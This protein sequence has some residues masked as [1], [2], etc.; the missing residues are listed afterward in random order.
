MVRICRWT[1]ECRILCERR[2]RRSV[3][4][5][6]HDLPQESRQATTLRDRWHHHHHH[7]RVRDP[8]LPVFEVSSFAFDSA[9]L[10]SDASERGFGGEGKGATTTWCRSSSLKLNIPLD[11][12]LV[13]IDDIRVVKRKAAAENDVGKHAQT[14]QVDLRQQQLRS[15]GDG[16]T[17]AG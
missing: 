10:P 17:R 4:E 14:P 11:D 6:P 15:G 12:L 16:E 5:L 2:K 8:L 3:F 7:H 9:R 1:R 13:E